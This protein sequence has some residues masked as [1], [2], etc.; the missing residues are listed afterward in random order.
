MLH[1]QATQEPA[2]ARGSGSLGYTPDQQW[3]LT[4]SRDLSG[5]RTSARNQH[6]SL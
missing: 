1:M 6:Q 4:L 2:E 5:S 3:S